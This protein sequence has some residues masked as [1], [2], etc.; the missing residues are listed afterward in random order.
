MES[1]GRRSVARPRDHLLIQVR[2]PCRHHG[3]REPAGGLLAAF[4]RVDPPD[5]LH[6]RRKIVR[7]VRQPPGAPVFHEFWQAATGTA[8]PPECRAPASRPPPSPRA[9]PT[10]AETGRP[11]RTPPECSAPDSPRCRSSAPGCRPLA[12][13]LR[14]PSSGRLGW[15]QRHCLPPSGPS[16]AGGARPGRRVPG[17]NRTRGQAGRPDA[18]PCRELSGRSRRCGRLSPLEPLP[19]WLVSMSGARWRWCPWWSWPVR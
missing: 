13:A 9:L 7:R 2:V 8:P 19:R 4:S 16:A 10:A 3:R 15:R 6:Q 11:A 12:G 17:Q 1:A 18:G 14:P 5:R